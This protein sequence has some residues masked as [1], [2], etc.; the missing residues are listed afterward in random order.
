[1]TEK[2][3]KAALY[4][5]PVGLSETPP[6][7][8]VPQ[9]NIE[10]LRQLKWL[11]VENLRTARRWIKRFERD[12]DIDSIHFAELNEH[13]EPGEI[14]EML[15]PLRRGE[16]MGLM[17]EAGCPAVADPGAALVGL[18]QREGLKV[19]PLVGPSS[20]LMS[21]MASG[22]N[23]QHFTFHGYLPVEDGE[24]RRKLLGLE[25]ESQKTGATQIFIE[26]PYRNNKMMQAITETLMD[27]TQVCVATSIT[28]PESEDIRTKSVREWRKE[29][30]DY[31]K[32]PT[33]FLLS[34]GMVHMNNEKKRRNRK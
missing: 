14:S 24:R 30:Y 31:G 27:D 7:E 4:L 20:I 25:R 11:V 17:S 33:I 1:M 21:L 19:V 32:K 12:I 15:D 10:I 26:T 6:E 29:G 22:F 9:I 13:T 18:A 2:K 16:A 34:A 23:G 3:I 28:D 5:L 8:T